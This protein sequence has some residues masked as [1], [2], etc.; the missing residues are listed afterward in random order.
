M[1]Y[2]SKSFKSGEEALRF[3]ASH[4]GMLIDHSR[5][6]F[7]IRE[8]AARCAVMAVDR[9]NYVGQCEEIYK[10]VMLRWRYVQDPFGAEMIADNPDRLFETVLGS[11]KRPG[12]SD[13]DEITAMLG[14][15]VRAIGFDVL[16]R[17]V[18]VKSSDLP[19]HVHIVAVLPD[20]LLSLDPVV[21]PNHNGFGFWPKGSR[22]WI[23]D[24]VGNLVS[25]ND[26]AAQEEMSNHALPR[27]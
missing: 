18:A 13:C 19:D 4:I 1:S 5:Y 11:A 20:G 16:I 9:K 27:K 23:F 12:A 25:T 21:E 2:L 15:L 24:T 8:Y 22:D 26:R 14:C 7:K 3:T 17:T 10:D 6:S